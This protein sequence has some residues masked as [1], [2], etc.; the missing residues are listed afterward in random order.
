MYWEDIWENLWDSGRLHT[1]QLK[2]ENET[3]THPVIYFDMDGVLANWNWEKSEEHPD[4][5]TME[6][7]FTPGYFRNLKPIKEY[8]DLITVLHSKGVDV[9][10]LSKACHSAIKEKW[11]WIQEYLPFMEKE[12][13]YFVP[14]GE[15]KSDFIPS[16]SNYDIL[17]DD[18]N[19]NLYEWSGIPIKA[20]TEKNTIN[21][22]FDW[23][24]TIN[25]VFKNV[26]IIAFEMLN[27]L[28]AELKITNDKD[29][30]KVRT[31][32]LSEIF[33]MNLVDADEFLELC[34][35]V[36]VEAKGVNI[37][38]INWNGLSTPDIDDSD[39]V[40]EDEESQDIEQDR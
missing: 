26:R 12:H 8:V 9:R 14:L 33:N 22:S 27:T 38:S 5:V 24:E 15:A 39:L 25:P 21:P 40:P 16:M 6:E 10:I 37:D 31:D 32:R 18:Y 34:D 35:T 20:I 1:L 7:V 29:I 19:P 23:I 30:D 17:I 36:G 13:V 4:G 2:D 28:K 11:D 3:I